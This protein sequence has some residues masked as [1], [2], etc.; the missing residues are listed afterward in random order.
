MA[1][2]AEFWE[3]MKHM[4]GRLSNPRQLAER[5]WDKAVKQGAIPREIV[6]GGHGYLDVIA[7]CDIDCQYVCMAATFINQ[8]RWEQYLTEPSAQRYLAGPDLRV[9]K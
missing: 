6:A 5:A 8:W 3:L 1:D 4:R 7:D 9:V 2:F